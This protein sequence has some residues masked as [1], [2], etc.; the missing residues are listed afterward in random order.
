MTIR[1]D[2]RGWRLGFDLGASDRKIAVVKDGRLAIAANGEPVLSAEF[3]WDPKNQSNPRWHF[4]QIM[5][6]LQLGKTRIEAVAPGA[7]VE[8]I[9]GSSAR[10]GVRI[11]GPNRKTGLQVFGCEVWQIGQDHQNRRCG[12]QGAETRD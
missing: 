3:A 4:D 5:E 2:W 12:G 1:T 6:I 7:R 10:D 9:G 8:A 11:F